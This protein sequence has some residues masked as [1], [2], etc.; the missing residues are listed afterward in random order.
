M[1]LQKASMY[2]KTLSLARVIKLSKELELR[3]LVLERSAM[4]A[5]SWQQPVRLIEQVT[6][7]VFRVY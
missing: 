6:L 4:T 2:W 1:E 5:L 7:R 3:P